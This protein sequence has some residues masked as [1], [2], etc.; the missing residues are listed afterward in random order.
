MYNVKFKARFIEKLVF[1]SNYND[2]YC[3]YV[4]W[5]KVFGAW[6]LFVLYQKASAEKMELAAAIGKSCFRVYL[7]GDF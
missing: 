1:N 6:R 2:L 7:S 5:S 4:V 3:R